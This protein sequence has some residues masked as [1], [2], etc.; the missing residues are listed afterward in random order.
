MKDINN[1]TNAFGCNY[2][3]DLENFAIWNKAQG[4]TN[5]GFGL[6]VLLF[7]LYFFYLLIKLLKVPLT[8]FSKLMIAL[9]ILILINLGLF[10]NIYFDF[11][12]YCVSGLL[13]KFT[14]PSYIILT[15]TSIFLFD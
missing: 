8:G 1:Y 2:T 5:I 7:M 4:Y 3:T 15:I 9:N 6:F 14:F 13:I 12:L 10:V 11:C